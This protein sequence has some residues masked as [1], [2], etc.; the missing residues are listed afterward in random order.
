MKN[1]TELQIQ[2]KEKYS[3]DRLEKETEKWAA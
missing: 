2:V 3:K 1:K